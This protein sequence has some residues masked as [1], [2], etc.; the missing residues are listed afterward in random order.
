MK[1][2]TSTLWVSTDPCIFARIIISYYSQT[3]TKSPRFYDTVTIRVGNSVVQISNVPLVELLRTLR[4]T[5]TALVLLPYYIA[6]AARLDPARERL[7]DSLRKAAISWKVMTLMCKLKKKSI[8][9]LTEESI[10]STASAFG[11]LHPCRISVPY[12]PDSRLL[13]MTIVLRLLEFFV[14]CTE[15]RKELQNM[16]SLT[17]NRTQS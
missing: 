3:R 5:L 12:C 11:Q 17:I 1:R 4:V 7:S 14:L 8:L 2:Y 9:S 6:H 16:D 10:I 13:A 15:R